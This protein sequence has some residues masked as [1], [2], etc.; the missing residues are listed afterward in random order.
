MVSLL[1]RYLRMLAVRVDRGTVRRLLDHPLGN[2]LRG[3]SDALDALGVRNAAYQLPPD[4]LDQVEAPFIAV[5]RNEK[6]PFCLVERKEAKQLTVYAEGKRL[7]VSREAF[8]QQWT[9]G[10]LVGETTAD[11]RHVRWCGLRN[12]SEAVRNH[13]LLGIGLLLTALVLWGAASELRFYLA[14]LCVGLFASAAVLYK[15]WVDDRFL[16]R[17]CH[18]GRTVDCNTVLR[19]RGARLLG[20]DLGEWSGFYFGTMGTFALLRPHDFLPLALGMG[21]GALA[22]TVYS[23]VYQGFIIKKGC[24]LCLVICLVVWLNTVALYGLYVAGGLM[25]PTLPAFL[26]L[27]LSAA[28]WGLVGWQVRSCLKIDRELRQR[29]ARF[30]GLLQPE[31]FQALLRQQPRLEA[32]PDRELCL[33]NPVTEGN[34]ILVVTNPSCG[35]CARVHPQVAELAAKMPVSLALL[36]FPRDRKG[37][38][39]AQTVMATYRTAGWEAAFSLLTAWFETGKLPSDAVMPHEEDIERW[40]RLQVYAARQQLTRTPSVL[41]ESHY[42]PEVYEIGDLKYVCT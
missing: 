30:G 33:H 18:I 22:F 13:R 1:Y 4:Y 12:G 31:A 27:A 25:V 6:E 14:M 39:V 7:T 42:L 32:L 37:Q 5:T 34:G 38:Q 26:A 36:T 10:I 8:L 24:M 19:S 21:I 2:S 16:H 15:E 9:G 29:R 23:I 28:L 41:I 35:N 11:T 17:F 40:K 3:L 20:L